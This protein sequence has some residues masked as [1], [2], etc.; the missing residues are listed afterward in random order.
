MAKNSFFLYSPKP[1]KK[2]RHFFPFPF[3][4]F[5]TLSFFLAD[6]EEEKEED[7]QVVKEKVEETT[8]SGTHCKQFFFCAFIKQKT[9]L[10]NNIYSSLYIKT[11]PI[12]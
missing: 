11:I 5:F 10:K 7:F 12:I 8:F 1:P 6:S 3:Y 2:T 9:E 4:R